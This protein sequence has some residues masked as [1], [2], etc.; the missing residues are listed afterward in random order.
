[1]TER[2]QQKRHSPLGSTA[3]PTVPTAAELVQLKA[4]L[5]GLPPEK[6]AEILRPPAPMARTAAGSPDPVQLQPEGPPAPERTGSPGQEPPKSGGYTDAVKSVAQAW[7][8]TE[9][10]KLVVAKAKEFAL[11]NQGLPFTIIAGTGAL[12]AMVAN[13]MDLPIGSLKLDVTL[14]TAG[15]KEF[16]L[17]LK[18]IWKG[19]L[20]GPQEVGGMITLSITDFIKRDSGVEPGRVARDRELFLFTGKILH[21]DGKVPDTN[22]AVVLADSSNKAVIK[23]LTYPGRG[24]YELKWWANPWEENQQFTL[25]VI[26]GGGGITKYKKVAIPINL[27]DYYIASRHPQPIANL[28][29][30][31]EIGGGR[32]T[33]YFDYV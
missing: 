3:Q 20:T 28:I 5:A 17:Q 21:P 13:K 12:A 18:P 27:K 10:G 16:S 23:N 15:G 2:V 14:G 11:S 33:M 29:L 19:P 7:L 25:V 1:M 4:E 32:Q 30:L 26:P 8:Q 6:Q 9:T 22:H 24:T 31:E